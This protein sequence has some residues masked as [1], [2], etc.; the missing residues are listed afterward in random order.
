MERLNFFFSTGDEEKVIVLKKFCFHGFLRSMMVCVSPNKPDVGCRKAR[1][2]CMRAASVN[3][4][5]S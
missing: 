2:W 3:K 1:V 5:R 4:S